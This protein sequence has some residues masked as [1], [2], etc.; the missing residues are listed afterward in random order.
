MTFRVADAIVRALEAHSLSR[1][2]CVPGESYLALLD[3]LHDSNRIETIVCRHESGAGFMA[4]AEAK[5]TGRAQCFMVSRGP[6][7]TNGSIA[8]H[9]AQQDATPLVVLVG[10]VAREERGR[11]AF[12]EVDYA[13]FFGAMAK[14]VWE[15]TDPDKIGETLVRAFHLAQS[16]VQGPV[17]VALPEDVLGLDYAPALPQPFPVARPAAS[18]ADASRLVTMLEKSQRPLLIAGGLLRGE[19]AAQV[20][21]AFAES[22][23]VPVATSWKNQDVF[24]NS[25]PLYAGHLGFGTPA[26]HRETLARADLVIAAGTRLGDVASLNYAFPTAPEPKQPLV[27]IY[28]DVAPIGK[29]FH[30]AL[31]IVAD[32]VELLDM[33]KAP[34]RP[35]A[36][37]QQW[38]QHISSYLADFMT[39]ES[40][41]PTDGVDFGAVVT[42]I[43]EEAPKNAVITTDAGNMST[44]V[45][46]H[47]KMSPQNLLLGTIGGAMG[48]GVPAGVASGLAQGDRMAIVFVGD[49]G[50]LM[51]GQELATA[52]QYGA[53]PKIVISDNGSYGT[54]RQHQE[55]HFP[56]RVSGTT[57]KNPDFSLWARSFG[58]QVV[59][60]ARGDDIRAKVREALGHDGASVLHVR[61]SIEA[62]SAFAT[63]RAQ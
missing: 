20:L 35:P 13:Q 56:K 36:E 24:D 50:V 21:K 25:S 57:L 34:A 30:T 17:I 5:I 62:I 1:V 55:R 2:Y 51:T 27:H 18:S 8:V 22:H 28:P 59:T 12:Q 40:S 48:F 43:A 52:L 41:Q 9:V 11:G 3:A 53:K 16:G 31:G 49:G 33:A 44:W 26:K 45:H 38:V 4:V 58:A 15:V 61:S 54:I 32:P 6:G 60:I 39:F 37:R 47:W 10:Q 29:V 23:Q 7:A 63:L 42:A 19:R 14:A 46:R